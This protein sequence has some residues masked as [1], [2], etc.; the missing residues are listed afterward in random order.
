M[1]LIVIA[2]AQDIS[3]IST[4]ELT[5]GLYFEQA[6]ADLAFI[7]ASEFAAR[8]SAFS[9]VPRLI[10]PTLVPGSISPPVHFTALAVSLQSFLSNVNPREAMI[11]EQYGVTVV[12]PLGVTVAISSIPIEPTALSLSDESSTTSVPMILGATARLTTTPGPTSFATSAL[13]AL[14]PTGSASLRV[15]TS[16]ATI[17]PL[18]SI[19]SLLPSFSIPSESISVPTSRAGASAGASARASASGNDSHE[20]SFAGLSPS[21]LIGIGIGVGLA[22]VVIIL[23]GFVTAK[24]VRR[25]KQLRVQ[26]EKGKRMDPGVAIMEPESAIAKYE[27]MMTE[28]GVAVVDS[29]MG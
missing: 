19:S 5:Y 10:P 27:I 7:E 16:P 8:D 17:E 20:T 1:P 18:F 29:R 15:A 9:N 23:L 28:P 25:T 14:G 4:F 3:N 11:A 24:L 6:V 12:G 26:L 22:G 2:I 21:S 13:P